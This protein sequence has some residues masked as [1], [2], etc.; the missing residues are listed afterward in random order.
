MKR[1]FIILLITLSVGV[2]KAQTS[3]QGIINENTTWDESGS[4]YILTG[5]V[6]IAPN[7]KLLING[8]VQVTADTKQELQVF[9][10]LQILGNEEKKPVISNISIEQ[11]DN[12]ADEE[13]FI[14]INYAHLQDCDLIPPTGQS[15]YG[16]YKVLNSVIEGCNQSLFMYMWYPTSDSEFKGNL[17]TKSGPIVILQRNSD[18][19]IENNFI[20]KQ[21]QVS[22]YQ[23]IVSL[24]NYGVDGAKLIVRYNS[25]VDTNSIALMYA[26]GYSDGLFNDATNNYFGKVSDP[27]KMI[28]DRKDDLNYHDFIGLTPILSGHHIDTPLPEVETI[29]LLSPNDK[30]NDVELN[31]RLLWNQDSNSDFYTFQLSTDGFSTFV[32][33]E[34][35]TDTSFT[36]SEL[37][38]N[39]QY[40]W[41]VRGSNSSVDGEWS[42]VWSFTTQVEPPDI[43]TIVSPTDSTRDVTLTPTLKWFDDVK[44]DY[45]EV[46]LIGLGREF[47]DFV[48]PKQIFAITTTDTTYTTPEL[49]YGRVYS[50]WV[51][52]YNSAGAGYRNNTSRFRTI[53][54]PL[55]SPTLST[56]FNEQVNV[57]TMTEFAWNEIESS[58]SYHLQ[59]SADEGFSSAV[60]DSSK[61]GSTS[62]TLSEPLSENTTYFWRMKSIS[63]NELRNSEWSDTLTFTTGVR[64]SIEDELI[65]QQYTLS[66]NYPNPFNPSTQIHYALPEATHVTLEV[67]NSVGQK[68]MELVNSQKS[69]GLH[70]ATFDASG[71]SSGVYLYKLTTPSFTETKKM[72]LIK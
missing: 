43:I 62:F 30:A 29:T 23:G 68:V 11:G 45:F 35:L 51:T 10:Y 25:F 47:G 36:T 12:E 40:S 66:Q 28:L 52:G 37:E 53:D 63:D 13:S 49:K 55:E 31:Q 38:Y 69:A 65:P 46:S 22:N 41:R 14:D 61:V 60:F 67:F 1:A 3:V 50:I 59:V 19:Y 48:F 32:V 9:G 44:A 70:T 71:L 2:V 21:I 39:T 7:V 64:T 4:P 6:Q 56:P 18:V 17:I 24:A 27:D 57:G 26:E 20:D 5:R 33:N 54:A 15:V 8:N 42:E 72:L 34:S 58:A 16:Y